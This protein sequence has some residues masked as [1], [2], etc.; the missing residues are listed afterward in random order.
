[1][2]FDDFKRIYQSKIVSEYN[3]IVP[4]KPILSICVQTYQ[5]QDFISQCLEGILM[6]ETNFAIEILLGEDNS[7]DGT[8][9]ICIKYAEKYPDKIR[10]F[11][12]HRENNISVLDRPTGRFNF[13][14]NLFSARGKYIAI[15]EGDDYWTDP[16][17]LQKQ[18][19]FL[20][21]NPDYVMCG[22]DAFVF[23]ENGI[24]SNSK[25]LDNHKR[26][27]SATNLK[28]GVSIL[29]MTICFRNIIKDI[30]PH[31]M[32]I[33]NADSF[34]Y[35]YLG[36][37]GNYKYIPEIKSAAY[38]VHKGGIW[39]LVDSETQLIT[40]VSSLLWM[41]NYF[42]SINQ[43]NLSNYYTTEIIDKLIW[44]LKDARVKDFLTIFFHLSKVLIYKL[45]P[46]I[47]YKIESLFKKK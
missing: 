17:K 47:Y 46:G 20:D 28:R 8:R 1:M 4:E 29:F 44:T 14:Y 22:H 37:F 26:D 11:L 24:I 16:L 33:I 42:K 36:Q 34:L 40:R 10:L 27:Y 21:A 45:S 32:K 18:V 23:D 41:G 12:H 30:P 39:S 35:A 3:N 31:F 7:S 38:R 6:Q 19:D 2:N 5:H 9:D 43:T 15:C 13:L 25:L